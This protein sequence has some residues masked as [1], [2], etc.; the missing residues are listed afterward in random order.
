VRQ[1]DLLKGRWGR[2]A[3]AAL[4]LLILAAG[5]CCLDQDQSGMNDHG[6]LIDLCLLLLLLAPAV[7]LLLVG[8]VPREFAVA[9][10]G[11]AFAAVPL[12]V[13]KP[14]PRRIHLA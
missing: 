9:F 12:A 4:A 10:A 7:I 11:P 13:P 6:S 5:F 2:G 8:F 1:R 14:P 3:I